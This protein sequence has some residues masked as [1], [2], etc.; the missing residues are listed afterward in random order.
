MSNENNLFVVLFSIERK[1]ATL[2][3]GENQMT[4]TSIGSKWNEVKVELR[5]FEQ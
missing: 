2:F 3:N 5:C 4:I 1:K